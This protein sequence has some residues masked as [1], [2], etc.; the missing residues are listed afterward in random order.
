MI[1]TVGLKGRNRGGGFVLSKFKHIHFLNSY[2]AFEIKISLTGDKKNPIRA[3]QIF[4][5]YH[6]L[7][8]TGSETVFHL[9]ICFLS[10]IA[11]FFI[12]YVK[13]PTGQRLRKY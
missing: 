9:I 7:G 13:K 8:K 11:I 4:V 3:G 5:N 2:R 12:S 6:S 10:T 1:F